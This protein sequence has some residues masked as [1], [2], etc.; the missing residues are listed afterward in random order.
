MRERRG[1][2]ET[3]RRDFGILICG[4]VRCDLYLSLPMPRST[5]TAQGMRCGQYAASKLDWVATMRTYTANA[6]DLEEYIE[7]AQRA[8]DGLGSKLSVGIDCSYVVSF[9]TRPPSVNASMEGHACTPG[10]NSQHGPEIQ[11]GSDRRSAHVPW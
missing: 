4:R 6:A 3:G 2:G 7:G 9:G 10:G 8:I 11:D 5:D 1:D